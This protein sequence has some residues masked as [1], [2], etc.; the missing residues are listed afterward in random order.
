MWHKRHTST[1]SQDRW[2]GCNF[3]REWVGTVGISLIHSCASPIKWRGIWLP[4][5]VSNFRK[6]KSVYASRYRRYSYTHVFT[7]ASTYLKQISLDLP[8]PYRA[9]HASFRSKLLSNRLRSRLARY[10]Y[11]KTITFEKNKASLTKWIWAGPPSIQVVLPPM[12][13]VTVKTWLTRWHNQQWL[14][15]LTHL[16]LSG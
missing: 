10:H 12:L 14:K 1:W 5:V 9:L 2:L 6:W 15:P 3:T 4:S 8:T 7:W 16:F 13:P 11:Q